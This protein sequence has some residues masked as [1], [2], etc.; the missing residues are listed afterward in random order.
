MEELVLFECS[1]E[2]K[3]SPYQMESIQHHTVR[4]VWSDLDLRR[5]QGPVRCT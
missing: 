2:G 3:S 1:F 4:F 5:P